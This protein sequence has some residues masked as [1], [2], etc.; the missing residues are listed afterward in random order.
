MNRIF[1]IFTVISLA[2]SVSSAAQDLIPFNTGKKWGY[3]G[4]GGAAAIPPRYDLAYPF[5]EDLALIWTKGR[6]GF[7]DKAGDS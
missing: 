7:I 6:Y 3:S 5:S 1:T 2:F 4:P